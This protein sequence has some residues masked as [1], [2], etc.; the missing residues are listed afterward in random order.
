[1]PCDSAEYRIFLTS[2][3]KLCDDNIV[4][5]DKNMNLKL[6]TKLLMLGYPYDQH[7]VSNICIG[8]NNTCQLI[9]VHTL[10]LK[11][12]VMFSFFFTFFICDKQ[13]NF[14]IKLSI[15]M[16]CSQKI[17]CWPARQRVQP[18]SWPTLVQPLKCR[19]TN[20]HGLVS[21]LDYSLCQPSEMSIIQHQAL[22][23]NWHSLVSWLA[24]SLFQPFRDVCNS[25]SAL[26]SN[27]HG[28]VTWLAYSL[29]QPFR[30]V[31]NSAP[32][33]WSNWHGLI[34]WLD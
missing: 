10:F 3:S 23:S 7:F 11:A 13:V 5:N 26:W 2:Y 27:W 12:N 9:Q 18:S 34:S 6:Y 4:S 16:N 30:D 19:A 14:F 31:C 24:Y 20:R 22:W 25:A 29:C 33:L 28:L 15:F 21:W 32:A 8:C 1:M 17:S